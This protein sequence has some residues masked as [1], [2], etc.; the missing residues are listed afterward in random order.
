VI[1][2]L[3]PGSHSFLTD[4]EQSVNTSLQGMFSST[5]KAKNSPSRR[6]SAAR[7]R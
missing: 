4:S 7:L 6:R 1:R 5:K 3:P 2:D